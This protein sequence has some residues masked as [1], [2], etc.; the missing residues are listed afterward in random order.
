MG[1][2]QEQL[3]H[4]HHHHQQILSIL[5]CKCCITIHD[6]MIV[7]GMMCLGDDDFSPKGVCSWF[8]HGAC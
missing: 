3:Y 7:S 8:T 2:Q 4:H 5:L 6:S 1:T